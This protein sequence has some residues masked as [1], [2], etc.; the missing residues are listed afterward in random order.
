MA[1]ITECEM[2]MKRAIELTGGLESE[3][4]MWIQSGEQLEKQMERT[5]GDILISVGFIS[6]LGAF[7][8]EYRN[9]IVN[10]EWIE[11]IKQEQIECSDEFRLEN[12]IGDSLEIQK[13]ILNGLPNN[14]VS[15]QNGIIMKNSK[16]YPLIIDPQ[17]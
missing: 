15:I 5:L 17:N 9:R 3:R 12:T 14:E 1:K 8:D 2:K 7:T 4:E 11:G 16:E 13:W 6:Y 10:K